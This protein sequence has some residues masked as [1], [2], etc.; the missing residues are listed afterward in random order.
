MGDMNFVS[1][2]KTE[3]TVTLFSDNGYLG[4]SSVLAR[5][6]YSGSSFKAINSI[7][8]SDFTRVEFFEANDGSGRSLL[9]EADC[10]AVK[11]EFVPQVIVVETYAKAVQGNKEEKL[12]EGEYSIVELKRYEKLILP[13]GF[14]AV[15]AGNQEDGHTVRIFENEECS[16]DSAADVYEKVLLFTLGSDD[17]RINFGIKEELSDD[18]LVAVAGGK[19]CGN[20]WNK[21]QTACGQDTKPV[22]SMSP[23]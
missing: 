1:Q 16:I 7:K 20:N 23:R 14:Y 11:L 18:E 9:V 2:V 21:C 13:R 4:D 15:F 22:I 5:G 12:A 3:S 10:E 6:E 17:I 19:T 8:V